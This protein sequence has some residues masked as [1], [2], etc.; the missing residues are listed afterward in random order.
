MSSGRA[1]GQ[2]LGWR[3][4]AAG[5]WVRPD[6]SRFCTTCHVWRPPRA[7]HC[8]QCG[9][10]VARHDHHCGVVGTCVAQRNHAPFAAF[11]V[12]AVAGSTVLLA[13]TAAQLYAMRWPWTA[14]AWR[15]WETYPHAVL[16]LFYVYP[17][18]LWGFAAMHVAFICRDVTTHEM[19]T[20]RRKRSAAALAGGTP[21]QPPPPE[22]AAA[23]PPPH[24][25]STR[26]FCLA[27]RSRRAFEQ[28][29]AAMQREQLLMEA[30]P[31]AAPAADDAALPA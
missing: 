10:C 25:S 17:C 3:T 27:Y 12:A 14:G 1:L 20:A 22:L 24:D 8:S 19:I 30:P 4:D 6:G 23:P 5:Q 31:P 2:A 28:A 11:L 29:W 13:A 16:L 15:R 18:L 26:V 9:F 21:E 7:S